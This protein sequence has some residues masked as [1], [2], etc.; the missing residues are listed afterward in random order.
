MVFVMHL[1]NR[2]GRCF[3]V[4]APT[5]A[6]ERIVPARLLDQ[7]VMDLEVMDAYEQ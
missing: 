2:A 6:A 4:D 3:D 1:G 7:L 5:E